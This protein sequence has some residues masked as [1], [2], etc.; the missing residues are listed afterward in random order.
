M[1]TIITGKLNK[2]MKRKYILEINMELKKK[3]QSKATKILFCS[4]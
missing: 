4:Y 2:T 3:K 1:Y